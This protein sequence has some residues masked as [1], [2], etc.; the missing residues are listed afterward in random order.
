MP[1][2]SS[3]AGTV[4]PRIVFGLVFVLLG[5]LWTLDNFGLID[6]GRVTQF[7]PSLLIVLGVAKM[8]GTGLRRSPVWGGMAIL[9]GTVMLFHNIGLIP[10]GIGQLWP[11]ALVALGFTF[12]RRGGSAGPILLGGRIGRRIRR[13]GRDLGSQPLGG[14]E[15]LHVAE[16]EVSIN[17][18]PSD[19]FEMFSIWSHVD[20]R[21]VSQ[22][23]KRGELAAVMGGIRLDL[24]G[25]KP[26]PEG[27]VLDLS[28]V[29][30]GV[31]IV[32]PPGWQVVNEATVL[33]GG[34]T[35]STVPGTSAS[36][37]RLILR[38]AVVMGGVEL[39]SA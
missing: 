8:L 7:W 31:E 20:R 5:V 6:S 1:I 21:V 16:G 35:D 10:F 39:K 9:V 4:T 36:G 25:A 34:M 38:G 30:G 29:W 12:I 2:G 14:R 37:E 13:R 26:V 22:Q 17:D 3:Q 27:A 33:I 23:F 11:L 28:V 32:V 18:D 24:R 19:R 15:G